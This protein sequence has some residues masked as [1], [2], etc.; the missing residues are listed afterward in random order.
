MKKTVPI[1]RANLPAGPKT[2]KRFRHKT[3]AVFGSAVKK[4]KIAGA[5]IPG[6]GN[7]EPKLNLVKQK[8]RDAL[9]MGANKEDDRYSYLDT[10]AN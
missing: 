7:Y 2:E 3:G 5:D 6:P 8:T 1:V 9:I 10:T 4:E